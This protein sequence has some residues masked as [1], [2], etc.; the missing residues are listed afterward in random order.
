[1]IGIV[2]SLVKQK[3]LDLIIDKLE[4]L[5][6]LDIQIVLLGNG[7]EYYEDIFQFYASR[8]PSRISTNIVFVI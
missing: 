1:M 7:E 5:L 2:T 4:E 3:G 8:Y 6:S